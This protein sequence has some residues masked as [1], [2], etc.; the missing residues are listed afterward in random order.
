MVVMALGCGTLEAQSERVA[1]IRVHGNTRLTDEDVLTIAGLMVGDPASEM[2]LA[3][4]KNRLEKSGKFEAV[5]VRKRYRTLDGSEVAVVLAV[6]ERQEGEGPSWM[7][8]LRRL[9]S[10]RMVLP[11]VRYADGYGFTYGGRVSFVNTLGLGERW[12]IP[13]TWGGTRGA[14]LEVERPFTRGPVT[15][16][17]SRF[18]ITEETNP[19]FAQNDRRVAW[20]ARAEKNF[21]MLRFTAD[22]AASRVRFQGVTERPWT[23]GAI[24]AFDTRENPKFPSNAVYLAAGWRALWREGEPA[25]GVTL[26]DARG[27]WRPVSRVVIAARLRYEGASR[28]LPDYARLLIGGAASL[29]GA[30]AG[31]FAGD[32]TVAA[33]GELRILLLSP[34]SLVRLGSAVFIDAAKAYDAGLPASSAPWN[35]G[36]GIGFFAVVPFLT[37]NLHLARSFD[38]GPIRAHVSFGFTF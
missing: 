12:S 8:P 33:S 26:A 37:S 11:I 28:E 22:A 3:G 25:V 4:A 34:H 32:R 17:R 27:Y 18:G 29:R 2:R 6:H 7:R 1:E 10:G 21:G 30:P 38:G 19:H 16:L 15:S 24:L 14:L 5:E 20:T 9:S 31:K 13:L 23:S 36:A 35:P